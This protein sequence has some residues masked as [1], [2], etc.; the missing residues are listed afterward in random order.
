MKIENWGKT[1][2]RKKTDELWFKILIALHPYCENCGQ[3]AT[4]VHHFFPRG[5]YSILRHNLANG[6]SLCM[7]C[8]LKHHTGDPTI[9]KNILDKR[10]DDWY[11]ELLQET[12]KFN[13]TDLAHYKKIYQELLKVYEKL[14]TP[15]PLQLK[16]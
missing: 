16:R 13:K 3:Q 5:R 2:Y 7:G 10:G 9:E 14:F 11:D 8:H 15:H 6:I 4:Q 1:Q 12:K